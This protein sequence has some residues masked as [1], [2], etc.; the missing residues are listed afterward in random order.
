M[1][2]T[3]EKLPGGNSGSAYTQKL[4]SNGENL[5]W[6]ISTG[7]LPDGLELDENEGVISGTATKS[8]EYT[9]TVYA[10]NN[11]ASATKELTI[12]IDGA[13]DS[14]DD[15]GCSLGFGLLGLIVCGTAMFMKRKV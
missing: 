6:K 13:G 11:Y 3:T 14:D 7:N 5:K 10:S 2:I 1:T 9:F 4:E 12:S 15:G 8:G